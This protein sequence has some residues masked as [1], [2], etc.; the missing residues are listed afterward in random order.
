LCNPQIYSLFTFY[1]HYWN[2]VDKI[3]KGYTGDPSSA[4][5][6]MLDPEQ[7]NGFLDHYLDVPVDLSKVLFVCTA[8]T[9]DTIPGP[10]LDRMEII[11]LSGYIEEE[12]VQIAQNYLVPLALKNCGLKPEQIEVGDDVIRA[13]IHSY[14]RESGVRNLQKHVDKIYRKVAFKIVK[15]GGDQKVV[16]TKE[17]LKDYVGNPI[18]ISER[19]YENNPTG[20]ITGLAWTAMGGSTLYIESAVDKAATGKNGL[21]RTGQLGDVMNESASIAYTF[22]KSFVK[23]ADPN[24]TFFES[25][26]IH[27]HVPDG[28]TKKDGPSAGITMTSSLLSLALG[29]APARDVAMTGEITL[30]GKVLRIGGVK[31]KVIAAKRSGIKDI[32]I[33]AGNKADWDELEDYIK[34]GLTVHLVENYK[35][36]YPIIFPPVA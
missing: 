8:N 27:M 33:P 17:N 5:L 29:R 20:V 4:L 10:L 34:A 14:C 25:S 6:E 13:L 11:R 19:T 21:F 2:V 3:G 28:A 12:K 24:N 30:L 16:V 32:I 23:E 1:C 22:A 7:N 36:V 35:D 26:S 15:E 18:F 31:E 9:L